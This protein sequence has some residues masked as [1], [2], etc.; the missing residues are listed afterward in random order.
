MSERRNLPP[1]V[2]FEIFQHL[3][4][5]NLRY[6][7]MTVCHSWHLVAIRLYYNRVILKNNNIMSLKRS[8]LNKNEN[9]LFR[10]GPYIKTLIIA[11]GHLSHRYLFRGSPL[12][13]AEDFIS[14]ISHL[15][16]LNVLDLDSSQFY[17][18]IL[19]K[20]DTPALINLKHIVVSA[21][22]IIPR[23]KRLYLAACYKFRQTLERLD[24][25]Y[26]QPVS[27]IMDFSGDIFQYLSKFKNLTDLYIQN[28][29]RES[30]TFFHAVLE[31]CPCLIILS[32]VFWDKK[33]TDS[34][35]HSINPMLYL[36]SLKSI[37]LKLP[38]FTESFI[39]YFIHYPW[40]YRLS[41]LR[42]TMINSNLDF[43]AWMEDFNRKPQILDFA[44]RV[45]SI[46]NFR[47]EIPS[48]SNKRNHPIKGKVAIFYEFLYAIKGNRN[49]LCKGEFI[50]ETF[51]L[52]SLPIIFDVQDGI[53][54]Y[55]TY[56]IDH[57]DYLL[58]VRPASNQYLTQLP[59]VLFDQPSFGPDVLNILGFLILDTE[60][61]AHPILISA[62]QKC[63]HL[64][65]LRID[66]KRNRGLIIKTQGKEENTAAKLSTTTTT[67]HNLTKFVLKG[68]FLS[69]EIIKILSL[70][71]PNLQ[72]I[73]SELY[74]R[75]FRD[76]IE[77][78]FATSIRHVGGSLDHP[79]YVEYDFTE[80]KYLKAFTLDIRNMQHINLILKLDYVDISLTSIKQIRKLNGLIFLC[81]PTDEF[82]Q[83][84]DNNPNVNIHIKCNSTLTKVVFL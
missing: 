54:L 35:N 62:L 71:L 10:Y 20:W 64:K 74:E 65:K 41:T 49:M 66:N 75:E 39:S 44:K 47:I 16:N 72:K 57:N 13:S 15:P 18:Q 23:Y 68:G 70:H 21:N 25:D 5:E 63:P 84:Y 82:L 55:F 34:M 38:V 8:I 51:F 81:D 28:E 11:N 50:A 32:L 76:I 6:S 30:M 2:L 80:L 83:T 27:S 37:Y 22:V 29:M 17:M 77:G 33:E 56:V 4:K 59:C 78:R 36:Q 26:P 58:P 7:C 79:K 67:Q 73:V 43:Y 69:P 1:E 45:A 52:D 46:S 61:I 60:T 53:Q 19:V 40:N 14:L 31:S 48:K 42:I 12:L 3:T 24:L 9:G